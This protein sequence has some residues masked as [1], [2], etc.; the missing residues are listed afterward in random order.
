[1]DEADGRGR[2]L[3]EE[4]SKSEPNEL[5]VVEEEPIRPLM[6]LLIRLL[7]LLVDGRLILD[8][9]ILDSPLELPPEDGL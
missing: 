6:K 2:L 4:E 5:S 1:M 7:V 8:S 9:K 3:P